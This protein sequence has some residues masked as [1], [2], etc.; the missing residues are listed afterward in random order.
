VRPAGWAG[1]RQFAFADEGAAVVIADLNQEGG[2]AAVQHLAQ[3]S[4]FEVPSKWSG[5]SLE[6]D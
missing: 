4:A 6:K 5:P 3:Q 1:R 2:E